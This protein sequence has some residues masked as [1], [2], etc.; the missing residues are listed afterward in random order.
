MTG[1]TEPDLITEDKQHM[2]SKL[3]LVGTPAA[4]LAG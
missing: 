4:S 1:T 2:T 3:I